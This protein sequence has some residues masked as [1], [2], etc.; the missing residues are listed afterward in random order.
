MGGEKIKK[1][2]YMYMKYAQQQIDRKIQ[3]IL[4][5][6]CIISGKDITSPFF[7]KTLREVQHQCAAVNP[8]LWVICKQESI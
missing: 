4:K 8:C 3:I 1:Y 7:N 2:K 5:K 6:N